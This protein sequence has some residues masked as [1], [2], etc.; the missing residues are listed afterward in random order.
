ML[1]FSQD[2]FDEVVNAMN[3]G[4]SRFLKLNPKFEVEG[5]R[6]SLIGHSLGGV[7]SYELLKHQVVQITASAVLEKI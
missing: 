1:R 5:G 7:I 4:Y 2:I 6:V 3:E